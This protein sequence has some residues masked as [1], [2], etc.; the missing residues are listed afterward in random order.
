MA[1]QSKFVSSLITTLTPLG[2]VTA[3]RM[4]GG[5]GIFMEGAMFAL[6]SRDEALFLKADDVNRDAFLAKGSST[7]GKM[8]YYSTPV[9]PDLGFGVLKPWVEGAIAAANRTGKAKSKKS[10]KKPGLQ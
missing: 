5:Y 3:K 9:D 2:P 8:P 6:V 10:G 7:H 4:F 1:E